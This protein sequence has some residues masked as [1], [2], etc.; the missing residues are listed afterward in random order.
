MSNFALAGFMPRRN[1]EGRD[2]AGAAEAAVHG[3]AE[4]VHLHAEARSTSPIAL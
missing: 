3:A 4:D 2:R 1:F